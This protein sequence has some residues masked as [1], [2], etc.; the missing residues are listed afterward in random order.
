MFPLVGSTIV[1][2]FLSFPSF[3]A[4]SIIARQMRSL[5]DDIGLNDSSFAQTV[6]SF[7]PGKP[8]QP[9]DRRIADQFEN[10]QR[11][12]GHGGPFSQTFLLNLTYP[13]WQ[14]K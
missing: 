10:I 12:L 9:D 13:T 6:A 14:V 11:A 8:V 4:A 5:T 1:M 3:S 7:G 2:P